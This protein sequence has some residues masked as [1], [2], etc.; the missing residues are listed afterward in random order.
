M[1]FIFELK[2]MEFYTLKNNLKT[3]NNFQ[4]L[5]LQQL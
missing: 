1:N 3:S 2:K 4:Q 5:H